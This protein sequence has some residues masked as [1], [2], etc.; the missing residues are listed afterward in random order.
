MKGSGAL[1]KEHTASPRTITLKGRLY[2]K[3]YHAV[4]RLSR[5]CH[6]S[7]GSVPM[8]TLES[9]YYGIIHSPDYELSDERQY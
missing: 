5:G 8:K 3:L 6:N 9:L 1:D 4:R 2:R 7:K